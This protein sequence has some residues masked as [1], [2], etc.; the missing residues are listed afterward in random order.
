MY[1]FM[2]VNVN[3]MTDLSE[4]EF[5]SCQSSSVQKTLYTKLFKRSTRSMSS[6][7]SRVSTLLLFGSVVIIGADD[8][9]IV[10]HD[11]IRGVRI[12]MP[13]GCGYDDLPGE[14][15]GNLGRYCTSAIRDVS[16]LVIL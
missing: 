12:T 8:L 15:M 9:D 6:F 10:T 14:F 5:S 16:S 7:H 4:K 3:L 1:D 11:Q 2:N 13:H